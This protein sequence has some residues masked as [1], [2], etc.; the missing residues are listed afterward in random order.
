MGIMH[1][2]LTAI[3]GPLCQNGCGV[4]VFPKDLAEHRDKHCT[5]VGA[6]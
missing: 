6:A 4:R 1:G 2:F 5:K 3:F